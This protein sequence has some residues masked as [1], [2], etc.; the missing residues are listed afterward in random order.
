MG[1]PLVA[2]ITALVINGILC[3]FHKKLLARVCK[4]LDDGRKMNDGHC[5][6]SHSMAYIDG[7]GCVIVH[8][9]LFFF[10]IEIKRLF[11]RLKINAQK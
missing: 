10:V 11:K 7:T 8:K 6:Q 1:C 4:R 9:E 5:C 2:I 3:P